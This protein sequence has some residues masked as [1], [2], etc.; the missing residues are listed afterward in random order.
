MHSR[1]RLTM[2][3]DGDGGRLEVEATLVIQDG[4]RP[5]II[6]R[7]TE[8]DRLGDFLLEKP[9]PQE[10]EDFYLDTEGGHLARRS[11][12]LRHR[13][14]GT[15]EYLT[16]KGPSSTVGGATRRRFEMEADWTAENFAAVL[17]ELGRQGIRAGPLP[18]D[19]YFKHSFDRLIPPGWQIIHHRKINRISRLIAGMAEYAEMAIDAV[20]YKI[21]SKTVMH[22][23]IEVEVSGKDAASNADLVARLL[24]KEFGSCLRPWEH[25]KLSTCRGLEEAEARHILAALLDGNGWLN[26][27]AYDLL[28]GVIGI[29]LVVR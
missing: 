6:K 12:I 19:D 26:R 17:D 7:L 13:H 22:F 16:L 20:T 11:F 14:S 28:D 5:G 4:D 18:P 27:A 24:Q 23:E 25:G 21:K 10:L 29:D 9:K 15:E 1:W 3:A 2:P 8:L